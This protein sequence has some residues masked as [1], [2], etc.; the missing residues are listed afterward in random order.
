MQPA[1][2]QSFLSDEHQICLWQLIYLLLRS[3]TMWNECATPPSGVEKDTPV[4][5]SLFSPSKSVA[6]DYFQVRDLLIN[7]SD[8]PQFFRLPHISAYFPLKTFSS[9]YFCLVS[10]R[11][12]SRFF[13]FSPHVI[14]IS[15]FLW[16]VFVFLLLQHHW[17]IKSLKYI[18]GFHLLPYIHI[19]TVNHTV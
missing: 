5:S 13:F 16:S 3:F 2:I 11:L 6:V 1:S 4:H 15:V 7:K 8:E 10:D 12:S 9:V 19:Y 14:R 17:F 18:F